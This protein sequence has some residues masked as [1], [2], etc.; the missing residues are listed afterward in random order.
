MSQVNDKD[1]LI[2]RFICCITNARSKCSWKAYYSVSLF[3]CQMDLLH[4]TMTICF[5]SYFYAFS[6]TF[7][8][9]H[10]MSC[11]FT[12]NCLIIK[13]VNGLM[14]SFIILITQF[15]FVK[16]RNFLYSTTVATVATVATVSMFSCQ[17]V[18]II[19]KSQ[20]QFW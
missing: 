14:K 3:R 9:W 1:Y 12:T 10:V 17:L 4:K 13:Q 2:I 6:L 11:H 19:I 18:I 8:Q 15:K 7:K 16:N 20:W 5:N